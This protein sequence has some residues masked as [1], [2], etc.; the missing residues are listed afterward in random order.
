MLLDLPW[1]TSPIL[2]TSSLG[3]A[4]VYSSNVG[5][6]DFSQRLDFRFTEFSE[7]YPPFWPWRGLS[8]LD[9][10]SSNISLPICSTLRPACTCISPP[11]PVSSV[12]WLAISSALRS[13]CWCGSPPEP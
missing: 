13:A 9:F 5:E 1:R 12:I 4:A 3:L 8:L 6:G 11:A 2:R 7:A 10:H